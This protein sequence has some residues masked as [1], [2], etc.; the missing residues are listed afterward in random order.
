M[1]LVRVM[2]FAVVLACAPARA[3]VPPPAP[4]PTAMVMPTI[5]PQIVTSGRGETKVA[6]DRALLDMGVQTRANTAAAAGAENARV[7]TA[8]ID[9]VRRLGIAPEQISTAGYNVY[10]EMRERPDNAA[11]RIT[12][13]VVNNTVRVEIRKLD[14]IGPVIDA[15]LAAGA[16]MINSLSFYVS[17]ETEPKRRA[18]SDAVRDA[19]A[20]A[21]ALATAAGGTLGEL[22]ELST[23]QGG[24]PRPMYDMAMARGGAVAQA[25]PTP[26]QPGEQSL[27][28]M[29][30]ARWRFVP[31]A[32]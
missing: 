22:L 9:A 19:R 23:S 3:Q 11:P 21:E 32:R 18:L 31:G 30:S 4:A 15:V 27:V 7:Q 13:Y 6:P 2:P 28:V 16:N 1:R 8:I 17:N 12:G 10:P 29:V 24:F 20:E 14:Q 26:I 25:A 5:P